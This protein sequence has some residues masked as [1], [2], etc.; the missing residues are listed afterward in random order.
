M[1]NWK[2]NK[3]VYPDCKDCDENRGFDAWGG[4]KPCGQQNCWNGCVVCQYNGANERDE[5]CALR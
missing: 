4:N 1:C 2:Q 5:T 3:P